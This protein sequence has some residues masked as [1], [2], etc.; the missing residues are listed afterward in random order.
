MICYTIGYITDNE[1]L[2]AYHEFES[3]VEHL[4]HRKLSKPERIKA[5]IDKKAGKI[6]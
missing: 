5:V 3:R 6:T 2:Q 1:E 4:K